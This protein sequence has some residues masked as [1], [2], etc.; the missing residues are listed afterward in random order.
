MMK[1][2]KY[3]KLVTEEE[4]KYKIECPKEKCTIESTGFCDLQLQ[5]IKNQTSGFR[6]IQEYTLIG[7]RTRRN[8]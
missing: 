7:H 5:E 3:F 6:I 8:D 4:H 2:C 1:E